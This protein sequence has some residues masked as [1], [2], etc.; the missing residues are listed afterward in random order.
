MANGIEVRDVSLSFGSG[1][2]EQLVLDSV[3]FSIGAGE[4]FGLVGES[5][6][7]KSTM[8]RCIAGL[9]GKWT[10]AISI[11]GASVRDIPMR[12]RS[13]LVQMVFQDPYGSLH[14]KQSIGNQMLEPIRIHRLR[15]GDDRV[16][17]A[18]RQVGLGSMYRDRFPHQLSGGQRQRVV[19]ARC[20]VLEPR[21]LLLD[22]PTSA[23]DVSVQAE[24]LNLLSD[25][26]AK[27]NLSYVLV[28]H[29]LGVITHMCRRFAVMQKGVILE[30]LDRNA[31]GESTAM[32]EYSRLLLQA[33]RS[34]SRELAHLAM[35]AA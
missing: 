7:G 31:L 32:T 27:S 6:S 17:E 2:T 25:V 3:S 8:L 28:S 16:D 23:L 14:P 26:Q 5:G 19:I 1:R 4:I 29:D 15:D 34:Y 22:E 10:G 13:R 30:T 20:L 24:I 35:T 21:I 9:Y 33:S 12:K 11:D 18:L